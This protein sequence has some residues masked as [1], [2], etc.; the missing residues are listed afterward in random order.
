MLELKYISLK[1]FLNNNRLNRH[2]RIGIVI[3]SFI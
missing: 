3:A 1:K 2:I